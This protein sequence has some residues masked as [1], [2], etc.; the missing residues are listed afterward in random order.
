MIGHELGTPHAQHGP[1]EV[2]SVVR[3]Q[4]N[5]DGTCQRPSMLVL[6]RHTPHAAIALED[7][8]NGLLTAKWAELF[9]VAVPNPLTG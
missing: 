9:T 4:E 7:A 2:G 8:P 6:V 1:L 5:K 3:H